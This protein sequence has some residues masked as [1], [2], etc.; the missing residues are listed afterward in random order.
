MDAAQCKLTIKAP[1]ASIEKIK[2]IL[3]KTLASIITQDFDLSPM[4]R[5]SKLQEGAEFDIMRMT[6]T[7][8]AQSNEDTV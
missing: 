3:A 6:N 1:R 2:T 7:Y 4:A 5:L 8:I